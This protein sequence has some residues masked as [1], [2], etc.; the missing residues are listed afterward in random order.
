MIYK[1]HSVCF[2]VLAMA[3]LALLAPL[4]QASPLYSIPL[5]TAGVNA[6]PG[7][8][9]SNWAWAVVDTPPYYTGDNFTLPSGLWSITKIVTW[10]VPSFAPGS[11]YKLGD[12]FSNVTLYGGSATGLTS[13]ATGDLSSGSDVN[14]NSDI[15][16]SVVQYSGGLDYQDGADSFPVYQNT[17]ANLDWVVQG[18]LEYDFSVYGAPQSGPCGGDCSGDWFNHFT[19]YKS[20]DSTPTGADGQWLYWDSLDLGAGP[21]APELT[22]DMNILIVGAE[23]V[24]EPGT[25]TLIGVG[26]VALALGALRRG[27]R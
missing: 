19:M 1:S 12:E 27:K 18:G 15:T 2:L 5:P 25:V 6:T 3:T 13:L 10:S 11:G 4:A 23:A 26:L 8:N 22:G 20:P 17:F 7:A 24:P 14:S 9:R 21:Y 16:H